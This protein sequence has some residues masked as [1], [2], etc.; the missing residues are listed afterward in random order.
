MQQ[1]LVKSGKMKEVLPLDK[2]SAP[3]YREKALKLV[4]ASH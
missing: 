3:E 1:Q 4:N 2:I